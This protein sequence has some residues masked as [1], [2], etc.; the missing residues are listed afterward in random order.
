[1]AGRSGQADATAVGGPVHGDL[2]HASHQT[3]PRFDVRY[4]ARTSGDWQRRW[5]DHTETLRAA[6]ASWRRRRPVAASGPNTAYEFQARSERSTST[7]K[8]ERLRRPTLRVAHLAG[9]C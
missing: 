6:V 7:S 5:Q 2:G 1:M 8:R 9:G 4:P 3:R